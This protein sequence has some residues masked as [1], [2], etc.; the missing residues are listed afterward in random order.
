MAVLAV[1]S[2]VVLPETPRDPRRGL[3][4]TERWRFFFTAV[5]AFQLGHVGEHVA[6]MIQ[7]HVLR[8]PAASAHGIVGSLDIEWVHFLWSTF[9]F[10]ATV[11]LVRELPHN[12]WLLLTLVL[13]T[14]HELEHVTL[15]G[16][17]LT[18]G[19][20]GAPGLLASGGLIGG[21]LPITR[22]DLHFLYNAMLT[23]PLF[24][25]FRAEMLRRAPLTA[26]TAR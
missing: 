11:L 3:L 26:V 25:A 14:W 22:P 24:L 17:Y 13:A 10:A 16:T 20:S 15:I 9:V 19:V 23:V 6:Q 18:T 1:V 12:R 4:L 8:M 7:L 5:L 2:L 21:G